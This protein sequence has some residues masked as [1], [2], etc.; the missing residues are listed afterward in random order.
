MKFLPFSDSNQL[1]GLN[2][3]FPYHNFNILLVRKRKN[4]P[5]E[6]KMPWTVSALQCKISDRW[7]LGSSCSPLRHRSLVAVA[8]DVSELF[9]VPVIELASCLLLRF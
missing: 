6:K 5:S 3:V 7:S 9:I 8:S 4:P 1:K 2:Y